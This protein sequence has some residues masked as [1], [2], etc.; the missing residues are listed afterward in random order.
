V[1][2]I[3]VHHYVLIWPEGLDL[4]QAKG[5]GGGDSRFVG[6]DLG[7]SG[8]LT[9]SRGGGQIGKTSQL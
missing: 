4:E 2:H 6:V 1:W 3:N 8:K 9:T 5:Y 7:M